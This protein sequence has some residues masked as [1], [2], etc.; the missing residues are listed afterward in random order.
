MKALWE[1]PVIRDKCRQ[2]VLLFVGGVSCVGSWEQNAFVHCLLL[3]R[4]LFAGTLFT[5]LR[6]RY[7]VGELRL[8]CKS[9]RRRLPSSISSAIYCVPAERL[10]SR[11]TVRPRSWQEACGMRFVHTSTVYRRQ[12]SKTL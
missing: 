11:D 6:I 12:S 7:I 4:L 8:I 2:S 10:Q 5:L 3:E 9:S 1:K